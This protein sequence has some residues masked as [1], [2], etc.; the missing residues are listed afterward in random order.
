M[1]QPFK[2]NVHVSSDGLDESKHPGVVTS[3][4]SGS[5]SVVLYGTLHNVS[6]PSESDR[7]KLQVTYSCARNQS[8]AV[9]PIN[10]T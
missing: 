8:M 1:E 5:E 4:A 2:L 7:R 3:G 9:E 10:Q 6:Y